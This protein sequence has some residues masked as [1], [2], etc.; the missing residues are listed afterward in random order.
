VPDPAV[1]TA[2]QPAVAGRPRSRRI[3]TIVVVVLAAAL[4][5]GGGVAAMLLA[6]KWGSEG[7]STSSDLPLDPTDP[8]YSDGEDQAGDVPDGWERVD[9][10]EGFSLVLPKGWKRQVEKEQIDYT[11]DGGEHFVRIAIDE[12]PDFDTPFR[13]L[14]DLETQVGARLG[15]YQRV[16]LE[17]NTFRD[18]PGALWDFTWNALA[19]DTEFPGPRRAIEQSYFDRAGVEYVIYMSSPAA[20]WDTAREQFDTILRGW[21]PP[22]AQ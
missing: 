14:A 8:T 7:T 16:S 11:P 20:D 21:Q 13:H 15:D 12:S 6:D 18:R 2:S 4:L 1:A 10:V 19:K 9:D 22:P 17:T 3:R 5:G